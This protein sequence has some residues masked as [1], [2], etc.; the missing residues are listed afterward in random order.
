MYTFEISK[1]LVSKIKK[2]SKDAFPR[3]TIVYLLG[4]IIYDHIF[5]HD[6]WIPDNVLDYC[7]HYSVNVKPEWQIEAIE[8]AKDNELEVVGSCHSHPF[9]K[10][11]LSVFSVTGA[12]QSESDIDS[13]GLFWQQISGICLVK[14]SKSGRL[15][16]SIRFWG[17]TIPLTVRIT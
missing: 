12:H 5:V 2:I 11:E 10:E 16:S 7:T 4:E 17:P 1:S 6:L 8:Y 14:Q 15:S 13:C 9:T 3:E